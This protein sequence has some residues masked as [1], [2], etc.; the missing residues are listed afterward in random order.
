M[1]GDNI[2]VWKGNYLSAKNTD[3]I[4]ECLKNN[5]LYYLHA[6]NDVKKCRTPEEPEN[7]LVQLPHFRAG[8]DPERS[9]H[10]AGAGLDLGFAP[11]ARLGHSR[12]R[13]WRP[14]SHTSCPARE[15]ILLASSQMDLEPD[16]LSSP[17]LSLPPKSSP[18]VVVGVFSLGSH[19]HPCPWLVCPPHSRG[20]LCRYP[21]ALE[22]G[23]WERDRWGQERGNSAEIKSCDHSGGTLG[24]HREEVCDLTYREAGGC[25][26]RAAESCMALFP[27]TLGVWEQKM[28]WDDP[29]GFYNLW[30]WV[31]PLNFGVSNI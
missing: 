5:L 25:H 11:S 27:G 13:V 3:A 29:L 26:P 7:S 24:H 19:S 4:P 6:T 9:K 30:F 1:D 2:G 15:H 16:G 23:T 22:K 12:W 20:F 31:I 10:M 17:P 14:S 18:W 8:D 21:L 28:T